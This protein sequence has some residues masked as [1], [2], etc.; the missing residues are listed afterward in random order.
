MHCC[1]WHVVSAIATIYR[2][3][4]VVPVLYLS[5][6]QVVHSTTATLQQAH[7][8]VPLV[9]AKQVVAF[10]YIRRDVYFRRNVPTQVN[11]SLGTR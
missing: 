3:L 6:M 8:I 7:F 2:R 9:S 10:N 5:A 1:T 4:L 11:N